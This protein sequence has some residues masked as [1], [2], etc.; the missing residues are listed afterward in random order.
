LVSAWLKRAQHLVNDILGLLH[1][2][3][4]IAGCCQ[5]LLDRPNPYQDRL[6][7]VGVGVSHPC[8]LLLLLPLLLLPLV[9]VPQVVRA[10]EV[11][12]MVQVQTG[13]QV[14]VGQVWD[15]EVPESHL[16]Q[17]PWGV[18]RGAS[19][20]E[21]ALG[22]L[23]APCHMVVGPREAKQYTKGRCRCVGRANCSMCSMMGVRVIACVGVGRCW[24]AHRSKKPVF[25]HPL[26]RSQGAQAT[27][28]TTL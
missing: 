5:Q 13:T 28:D 8:C 16:G 17:V 14:L 19:L 21:G 25:L 12:Q 22:N 26:A 1:W 20:G 7:A 24:C 3:S 27:T 4:M 18:G 15:L 9:A 2:D 10:S 11:D 23:G 6:V